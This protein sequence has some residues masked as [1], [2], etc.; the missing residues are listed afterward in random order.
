MRV[1]CRPLANLWMKLPGRYWKCEG[2]IGNLLLWFGS[3]TGTP[4][5]HI[6][7]WKASRVDARVVWCFKI[8]SLYTFGAMRIN[9]RGR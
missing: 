4:L 9:P 8:M 1:S 6:G 2:Q 5:L 7:W 3:D